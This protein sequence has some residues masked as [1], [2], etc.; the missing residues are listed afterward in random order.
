MGQAIRS[1]WTTCV[2]AVDLLHRL[3]DLSLDTPRSDVAS[4]G[5][6]TTGC[7]HLVDLAVL[8]VGAASHAGAS[9]VATPGLV[10]QYDIAVTEP[11]DRPH[12]ATLELNGRPRLR[13]EA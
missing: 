7:T 11:V 4:L 13:W 10:R 2:E 12:V 5:G 8:A 1:P 6:P 9:E 3:D